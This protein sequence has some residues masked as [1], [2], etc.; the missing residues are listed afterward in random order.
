[1]LVITLVI[2]YGVVPIDCI[3]VNCNSYAKTVLNFSSQ[4]DSCRDQCYYCCEPC[5]DTCHQTNW[6][7]TQALGAPDCWP[8]YGD[9]TLSWTSLA[10]NN[11]DGEF[12]EFAFEFPVYPTGIS[13]YENLNAQTVDQVM[14]TDTWTSSGVKHWSHI[15]DDVPTSVPSGLAWV[16]EPSLC[17]STT[18]AVAVR[19]H[20]DTKLFPGQ[21]QDIDAV[22]LTGTLQYPTGL[23]S[24]PQGRVIYVPNDGAHSSNGSIFDSIQFSAT[25]CISSSA[26]DGIIQFSVIAPSKSQLQSL[27]PSLSLSLTP[28]PS[29]ASSITPDISTIRR[30]L[31]TSLSL[32]G[33][34]DDTQVISAAI[35][36]VS[37]NL[38]ATNTKLYQQDDSDGVA[39]PGAPIDVTNLGS[40]TLISNI[41]LSFMISTSVLSSSR[42]DVWYNIKAKNSSNIYVYRVN[43]TLVM[44]C[45]GIDNYFT[46]PASYNCV[47]CSS[48]SDN[49]KSLMSETELFGYQ[50]KC[51]TE[52]AATFVLR[53]TFLLITTVFVAIAGVSNQSLQFFHL[54][55]HCPPI[56]N[57]DMCC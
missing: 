3:A 6:H 29:V 56:C 10:A 46:Q 24:D 1:M 18:P 57:T 12:L 47:P 20:L 4:W 39:K 45:S 33:G 52:T 21:W 35:V 31:A 30:S 44:D 49:D 25:D 40:S 43:V 28:K 16:F 26:S 14:V 36:A 48:I 9:S 5:P 17:P 34:S 23:V 22:E 50:K 37:D 19:I 7:A 55:F 53:I 8:V 38:D 32:A 51:R 54:L 15:Y 41:N 2:I 42:L 27:A 13:I 11:D